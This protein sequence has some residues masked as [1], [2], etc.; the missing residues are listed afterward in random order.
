MVS[1]RIPKEIKLKELLYFISFQ[2]GGGFFGAVLANTMFGLDF[3][4]ISDLIF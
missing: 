3:I 2:F 1:S 4:L